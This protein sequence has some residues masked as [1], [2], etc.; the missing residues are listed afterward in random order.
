MPTDNTFT[1]F[2]RRIRAGDDEAAAEL[3][4]RFEPVI[5]REVRLRLTD[6]A[7]FGLFDSGDFCQS[8][9]LS[10]FV[11]ASLGQ[12]ELNRPEDLRN[13]LLRMARNK[14][15]DRLRQLRRQPADGRRERAADVEGLEL[16][17]HEP[18]PERVAGARDLLRAVLAGLPESERRLAELRM[19]GNTWPQVAAAVG[20][21]AEACRKQLSRA[22][23]HIVQHLGLED[24]PV[25]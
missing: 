5:R 17:G 10:F 7:L 8:V 25:V 2:L 3:V 19:A 14:V 15:A 6:P 4:R 22:L 9:L 18:E 24:E 11:R 16:P 12:Y 21:G 23:D 20:A 13:L 1:E